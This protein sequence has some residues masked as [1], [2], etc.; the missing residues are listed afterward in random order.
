LDEIG[1]ETPI[2]STLANDLLFIENTINI[3]QKKNMELNK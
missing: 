2:S 1:V 3:K